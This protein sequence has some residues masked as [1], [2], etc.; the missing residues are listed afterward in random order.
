MT[1]QYVKIN[2]KE[3]IIFF[4]YKSPF[5]NMYP[6]KIEFENKTFHCTEQIFAYKKAELFE[7]DA[8]EK[9]LNC[10]NGYE[11]K[12]LGSKVKNFKP[13]IWNKHRV[14]IMEKA[15]KEKFKNPTLKNYLNKYPNAEFIEASPYDKFWGAGLDNKNI[16]N[17]L[18][19]N[20]KYPGQNKLGQL[21]K[22]IQNN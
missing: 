19:Q 2:N 18:K 16:I 5:S 17:T 11:A 10:K 8:C 20:K 22:K 12:K 14:T 7:K 4:G 1:T 13:E 9:I 21:L 6:T 15:L 3:Y